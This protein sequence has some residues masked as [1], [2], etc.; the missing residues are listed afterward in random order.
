MTP[1][2]NQQWDPVAYQQH[3]RFVSDLGTPILDLLDARKGERILDLGCGDGALTRRLVDMGCD[4]VAVDSSE[5]MVKAARAL[6]VNA[7]VMNG[8]SLDFHQEFDAVFSNAALHWMPLAEKVVAGVW[9]ALK[10]GGRFVAEFGGHGNVATIVNALSAALTERH[11][12]VPSPWFFPTPETYRALLEKQ[13]FEVKFI[14]LVPRPTL[15]PGDV[16][17]WLT[18]F[19]QPFLSAV[20]EEDRPAFLAGLVD[21]LRAPM[22]DAEGKWWADYVR[23]RCYAGKP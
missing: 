4:V 7:K 1:N 12:N 20:V 21:T 13:G 9:D 14:A 22:C 3:G 19:A 17:A 5:P 6:G 15:L 10:P 11:A 23:I 16:R 8:E 18:T 2:D